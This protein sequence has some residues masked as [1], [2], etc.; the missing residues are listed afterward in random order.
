[1]PTVFVTKR[2]RFSAA[3]R[4][5]APSLSEAENRAAYGK[6]HAP[7]PHGHDYALEVTVAGEPDPVTGMVVNVA[8]LKRTVEEELTARLDHRRLDT[9][10]PL[11]AGMVPTMENLVVAFW[12]AL[13]GKVAPARLAR[14][15]L[16]ETEDNWVDYAGD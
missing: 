1:M 11:L 12:R 3:H 4:L 2:L 16:A 14:L 15:R 5:H 8:R 9:E 13:E 6:C 10:V 7:S